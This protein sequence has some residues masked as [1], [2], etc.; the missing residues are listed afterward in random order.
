M[1]RKPTSVFKRDEQRAQW[2]EP[3]WHVREI[4]IR[5]PIRVVGVRVVLI[6]DGT[7]HRIGDGQ[8]GPHQ[9]TKPGVHGAITVG[10][11]MHGF[12]HHGER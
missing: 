6:V 12:M 11:S 5:V 4:Q 8:K 7:E 3:D 2:Q 1:V 9:A 10:D